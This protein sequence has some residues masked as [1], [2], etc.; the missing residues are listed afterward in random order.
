MRWLFVAV[1][2]LANVT[3]AH[4]QR[5]RRAYI[6]RALSAVRSLGD[7]GRTKLDR[8]LYAAARASCHAED[9]IPTPTC[10]IDAARGVCG[11]DATCLV[12]ADVIATNLRGTNELLDEAARM[13]ILR[14]ARDYRTELTTELVRRYAVLAAEL[15]LDG[16]HDAAAIDQL[17]TERDRVIHICEAG[18]PACIPSIPWSRCVAMLV[19]FVGATGDTR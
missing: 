2:A 14:R 7:A 5:D 1:V 8:D 11:S 19:W 6:E 9:S 4:A 16:R 3:T 18:A 13:R 15:V 12:V 17:C 10:L